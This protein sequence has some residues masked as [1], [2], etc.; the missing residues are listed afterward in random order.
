MDTCSAISTEH[1]SIYLDSHYVRNMCKQTLSKIVSRKGNILHIYANYLDNLTCKD[2]EIT[3][4][5]D[6]NE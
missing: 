5:F 4:T 2:F 1:W 3:Y 6:L